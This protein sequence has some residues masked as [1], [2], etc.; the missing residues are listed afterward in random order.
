MLIKDVLIAK[1]ERTTDILS[2]ATE[3]QKSEFAQKLAQNSGQ[4]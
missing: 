1:A 3:A 4:V 2:Q